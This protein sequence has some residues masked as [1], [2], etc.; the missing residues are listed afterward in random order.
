MQKFGSDGSFVS[1]WGSRGQEPGEFSTPNGI[2]VGP[3]G[4]V[5]VAD[6]FRD[7]MQVFSASGEFW[8]F[9][10]TAPMVRNPV[11][12][13]VDQSERLYVT[14]EADHRVAVFEP[15]GSLVGRFGSE[16]VEESQFRFPQ[17]IAVD[18]DGPNLRCRQPQ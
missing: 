16:G 12:V 3:S 1:V 17:G 11:G 9:A 6:T 2:A 8:R 7:R 18:A 14:E 5:Y 15:D 10:A 13:A 4:L